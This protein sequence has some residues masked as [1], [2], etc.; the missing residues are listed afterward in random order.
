MRTGAVGFSGV[1]SVANFQADLESSVAP[2]YGDLLQ[3]SY[4]KDHM[5]VATCNDG[6]GITGGRYSSFSHFAIGTGFN[7]SGSSLPVKLIDI[8]AT[9]MDHSYIRIDWATASE[10]DNKGFAIMRSDD[11]TNFTQIG[12]MDGHGN[13]NEQINYS[14]DDKTAMSGVTYY[15]KLNQMDIDGHTDESPLVTAELTDGPSMSVSELSP[16]PTSGPT[17]ITISVTDALAAKIKFFD[18]M[19][20]EV[21]SNDYSLTYG[22]NMLTLQ[23]DR[24]AHATYIVDILVGSKTFSKKLVVMK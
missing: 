4:F 20:R 21:T 16:N 15:Y 10:I 6:D 9:A 3:Y 1:P 18:I 12:W 7:N 11:G 2:N 23:T 8:T 22:T 5:T 14:Y 19:G 24:L 13:S 17:R